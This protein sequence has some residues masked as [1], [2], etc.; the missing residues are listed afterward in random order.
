MAAA[1]RDARFKSE[2]KMWETGSCLRESARALACAMPWMVS[3]VQRGSAL[4]HKRG[5]SV[6]GVCRAGVDLPDIV[7]C[8]AMANKQNSKGHIYIRAA[9]QHVAKFGKKKWK[10]RNADAGRREKLAGTFK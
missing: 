2:Q 8:L 7:D 5:G 10:K 4:E 1:V 9:H 6:L 3:L